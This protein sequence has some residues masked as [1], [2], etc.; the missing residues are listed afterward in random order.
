MQDLTL[1]YYPSD[2]PNLRAKVA[3]GL[4]GYEV[5]WANIRVRADVRRREREGGGR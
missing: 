5:R 2:D 4:L 1:Q 3:F